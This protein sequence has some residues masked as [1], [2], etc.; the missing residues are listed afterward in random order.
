MLTILCLILTAAII[1]SSSFYLSV[2]LISTPEYKFW[3]YKERLLC[4]PQTLYSNYLQH[5][6]KR[7][8]TRHIYCCKE[9]IVSWAQIQTDEWGCEFYQRTPPPRSKSPP[10]FEE[11]VGNGHIGV[12]VNFLVKGFCFGKMA[13]LTNYKL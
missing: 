6:V 4:N 7:Q 12:T 10:H 3:Y 8:I 2:N 1:I 5:S 11:K 13:E 9:H